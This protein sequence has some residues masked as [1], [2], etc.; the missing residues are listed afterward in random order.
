MHL[1]CP[2]R[3]RDIVFIDW[4][5]TS[6]FV[7]PGQE[8]VS[9]RFVI[10]GVKKWKILDLNF[11]VW[12]DLT[13]GFSRGDR[14]LD[15]ARSGEQNDA[16]KV[17]FAREGHD[18]PGLLLFA[19]KTRCKWVMKSGERQKDYRHIGLL[20]TNAETI[21]AT[22]SLARI[23]VAAQTTRSIGA[24]ANEVSECP[25]REIPLRAMKASIVNLR[26]V[27]YINRG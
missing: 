20:G 23:P 4:R 25:E 17:D 2:G 18:R 13:D 10:R 9:Y 22:E 21:N 6:L 27:D 3:D 26:W 8:S 24:L 11:G 15:S 16:I 5:T 19:N 1:W 14:V 12:A 7:D